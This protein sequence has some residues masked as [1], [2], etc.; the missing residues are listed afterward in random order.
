M[1]TH[2]QPTSDHYA[3]DNII[4]CILANATGGQD[5]FSRRRHSGVTNAVARTGVLQLNSSPE[6]EEDKQ[7]EQEVQP[8]PRQE[9]DGFRGDQPDEQGHEEEQPDSYLCGHRVHL[10]QPT[11]LP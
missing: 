9:V 2:I 4:V 3:D 6:D 7:T 1:W 11:G 8:D 5:V 10:R